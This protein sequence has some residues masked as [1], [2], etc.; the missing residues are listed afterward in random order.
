MR[1]TYEKKS[2]KGHKRIQVDGDAKAVETAAKV[3][4]EENISG[5]R[6]LPRIRKKK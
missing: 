6:S 3:A 5:S 1:F 4:R 2:G